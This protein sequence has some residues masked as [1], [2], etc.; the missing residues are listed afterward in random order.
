[1]FGLKPLELGIIVLIL[2]LL[3]GASKLPK[4]ARSLGSS[5]RE[6]RKGVEEGANANAEDSPDSAAEV[7]ED[8]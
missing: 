7:S 6:F 1:M 8:S 3:F 2:L 4:L 5:A